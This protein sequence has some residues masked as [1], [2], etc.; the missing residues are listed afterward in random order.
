MPI[1]EGRSNEP[2]IFKRKGGEVKNC[3]GNLF[4]CKSCEEVRFPKDTAE[5]R[6]PKKPPESNDSKQAY[7]AVAFC[8][9]CQ[10]LKT[11]V[12]CLLTEI[13][14]INIELRET[15]IKECPVLDKN[16]SNVGR[17]SNKFEIEKLFT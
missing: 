6:G 17:S 11:V 2:S 5:W 8:S 3:Q 10:H 1:C 15:Q 12:D 16:T 9:G 4:L 14:S 13:D 7:T